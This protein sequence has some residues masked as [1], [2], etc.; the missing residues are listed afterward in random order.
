MVGVFNDVLPERA[1]IDGLLAAL[2]RANAPM[3]T[4]VRHA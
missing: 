2:K 3:P 4:E 1:G